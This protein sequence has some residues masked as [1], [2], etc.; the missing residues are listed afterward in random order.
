M[1]IER[2]LRDARNMLKGISLQEIDSKIEDLQDKREG[3]YISEREEEDCILLL[4]EKNV[5]LD[6]GIGEQIDGIIGILD[7]MIS[8][9]MIERRSKIDFPQEHWGGYDENDESF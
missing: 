1:K 9:Q 6:S 4:E 7:G 5:L 2:K 8:R 3:N